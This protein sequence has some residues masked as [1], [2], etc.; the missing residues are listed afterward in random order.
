MSV[1]VRRL[2]KRFGSKPVLCQLELEV[3]AGELIAIFGPNG[4]GKTTLLRILA[5][6]MRP[7]SGEVS[8]AGF[9]LPQEA[10][11]VRQRLG[12]VA[13]QPLLYGELTPRE[14]LRFYG[15]LYGAKPHTFERRIDEVLELVG[16]PPR[17]EP[18]RTFSRGMQQ[19]LSIGR[20]LLHDPLGLLLDE[21]YTGL[22]LEAAAL[23]DGVL[24]QVHSAGK[25]VVLTTHDP[26]RVS[27]LAD[28][29]AVLAGGVIC[30]CASRSDLPNGDAAAF[31]ARA[32]QAG[33]AS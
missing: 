27:T 19:R 29:F 20:A 1:S 14:N 3:A 30:A 32:L 2:V 16:V 10:V 28:R 23:L 15:R 21:P 11:D 4:A 18:V 7:T 12:V 5:T 13:H 25:T 33:S 24:S 22:D 31:Y 6:L 8:V 17:E 26:A 9:T